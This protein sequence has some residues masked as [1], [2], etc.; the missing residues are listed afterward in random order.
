MAPQEVRREVGDKRHNHSFD[1][2]VFRG[3]CSLGSGMTVLNRSGWRCGKKDHKREKKLWNT[4]T[5]S[6][7][8]ASDCLEKMD[9][10]PWQQ[11]NQAHVRGRRSEVEGLAVG[12]LS[13]VGSCLKV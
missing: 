6:R 5:A 7:T 10:S 2:I 8:G 1:F 9:G 12:L 13:D 11:S 4:R 3:L